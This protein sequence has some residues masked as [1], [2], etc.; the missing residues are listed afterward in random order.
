MK[1]VHLIQ[2]SHLDIG[3]TNS[4]HGVVNK[5]FD[6]WFP[7][8]M[9]LAAGLRHAGGPERYIYTTHSWL[10]SLF[11]DCPAGLG[12]HCPNAEYK[13]NVSA[14]IRRGDITWH[15]LPSNLEMAVAGSALIKHSV[16][17][18]HHLDDQ[19]GVPRK[20]TVSIRDV[21]GTTRAA[22]PSLVSQGV[23][24]LS[25]GGNGSPFEANVPPAFVWR[26]PESA[27]ELLALWHTYGYGELVDEVPGFQ[28]SSFVQ[29]PGCEHALAYLWR[30]DNEGPGQSQ[31][32]HA[33][34]VEGV[35]SDFAVV[36]SWFPGAE[37]IAS[38]FDS[39]VEK[40][41]KEALKQLPVVAGECDESWV[42]GTASD[43]GKLSAFRALER[44]MER[45]ADCSVDSSAGFRNFTRFLHKN[46]EHTWGLSCRVLDGC[47][48]PAAVTNWQNA[49]FYKALSSPNSSYH[50]MEESWREMTRWGVDAPQDALKAA[51]AV[52]DRQAADLLKDVEWEFENISAALDLSAPPSSATGF[53]RLALADNLA[54]Q[55]LCG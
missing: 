19:F 11:F 30:D 38:T 9:E 13:H 49:D 45:C 15:A 47:S 22:I 44:V 17:L 8:A 6:D 46:P 1:T 35:R 29:I 48:G 25:L 55:A 21:P 20:R 54:L 52:G 10:I 2:S 40:V 43:P 5:Y 41:D 34:T 14:A 3:Y 42:F 23:E 31:H 7:T 36:Q 24:A 12:L 39:F 53:E 26:D 51:A 4:L 32:A 27:T 33:T 37:V 18:T 28:E 16:A 50:T